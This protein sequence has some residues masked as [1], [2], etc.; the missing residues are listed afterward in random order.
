MMYVCVSRVRLL[1]VMKLV[2]ICAR[3]TF[4]IDGIHVIV[5]LNVHTSV[6]LILLSVI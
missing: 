1:R 6:N 5:T 2:I 3:K 4:V